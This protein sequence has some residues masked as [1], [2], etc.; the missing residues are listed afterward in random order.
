MFI[1]DIVLK[2]CYSV[3]VLWV[4]YAFTMGLANDLCDCVKDY[5]GWWRVSLFW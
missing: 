3:L 4:V 1:Y 5:D 2:V